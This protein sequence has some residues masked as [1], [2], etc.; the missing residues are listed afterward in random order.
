[1]TVSED[2]NT[3]ATIATIDSRRAR[4][5]E[6]SLRGELLTSGGAQSCVV[7]DISTTGA[8]VRAAVELAP[9]DEGIL[10]CDELD[11][12][13]EVRW[14][15]GPVHGLT[16][17]EPTEWCAEEGILDIDDAGRRANNRRFFRLLDG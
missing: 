15:S 14:R 16:F 3:I 4:R 17:A 10:K 7:E 9:G 11:I 6:L 1:M 12:L 2:R 13:A 5:L 8:K